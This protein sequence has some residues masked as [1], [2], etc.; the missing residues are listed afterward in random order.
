[1]T[2]FQ[3]QLFHAITDPAPFATTEVTAKMPLGALAFGLA[4]L[5]VTQA[6]RVDMACQCFFDEKIRRTI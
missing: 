1:M 2:Q 3:V 6:A 4:R 5:A